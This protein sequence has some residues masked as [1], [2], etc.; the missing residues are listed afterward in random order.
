M[1]HHDDPPLGEQEM[2]LICIRESELSSDF[3][4]IDLPQECA[5]FG[6]LENNLQAQKG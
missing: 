3:E 1:G 4:E 2:V 6:E 5:R